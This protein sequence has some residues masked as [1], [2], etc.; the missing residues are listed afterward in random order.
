MFSFFSVCWSN[1]DGLYYGNA[2]LRNLLCCCWYHH[3]RWKQQPFGHMLICLSSQAL[4]KRVIIPCVRFYEAGLPLFLFLPYSLVAS[5][6]AETGSPIDNRVFWPVWTPVSSISTLP[7]PTNISTCPC[8][9]KAIQPWCQWQ[10]RQLGLLFSGNVACLTCAFCW[11]NVAF[12]LEVTQC[13]F[14]MGIWPS[15]VF[16]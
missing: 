3:T 16:L 8:P 7:C 5:V 9:A 1:G 11:L 2:R 15:W 14:K 13:P 4:N 12:L 10:I 6:E